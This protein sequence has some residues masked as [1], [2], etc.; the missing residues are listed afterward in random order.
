[1]KRLI[2]AVLPAA[3]LGLALGQASA[4]EGDD[5]RALND[6]G[7]ALAPSNI[8]KLS[9]DTERFGTVTALKE[10]IVP[11][12]G[13]V[14]VK[15]QAKSDRSDLPI[16]VFVVSKIDICFTEVSATD[17]VTGQ[18][19]LRVREGDSV[20]V[21]GQGRI[22]STPTFSFASIRN[23]RVYYNVKNATGNGSTVVD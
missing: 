7:R 17:Y 19:D 4:Q 15:W 16:D 21:R 3:L 2:C 22:D 8:L 5:G 13:V 11:Y 14:R 20:T 9:A 1:M 6:T 23:V 12:A 18:C 10:F